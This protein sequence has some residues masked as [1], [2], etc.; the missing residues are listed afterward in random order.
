MPL[1]ST[2]LFSLSSKGGVARAAALPG[3]F[4]GRRG[5]LFLQ[6]LAEAAEPLDGGSERGNPLELRDD[7]R[8]GAHDVAER[9]LRL[10]HRAK[11]DDAADKKRRDDE[12]RQ[13]LDEVVEAGRE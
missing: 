9:H 10:R 3:L 6:G 4:Q 1:T 7:D 5:F 13:Q 11:L 2:T 8:E 12:Q